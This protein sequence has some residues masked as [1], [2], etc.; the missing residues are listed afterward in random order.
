M[1]GSRRKATAQR[2]HHL[3][4]GLASLSSERGPRRQSGLG[5]G[6]TCALALELLGSHLWPDTH[7][8]ELGLNLI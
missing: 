2:N 4:A 1:R 5:V 8:G 6:W 3:W 7:P